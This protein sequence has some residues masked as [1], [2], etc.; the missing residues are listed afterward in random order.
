M[1]YRQHW[2]KNAD[3]IETQT[4][5]AKRG[6]VKRVGIQSS[7]I[8]VLPNVV[9]EVFYKTK[10]NRITSCH[11]SKIFC[12]AA[13]YPHKNLT[14]IPIV[15]AILKNKYNFKGKFYITIKK[16]GGI[17]KDI[18]RIAIELGVDN[19]IHNLGPIS[20]D[21]C[22]KYYNKCKIVFQP[23]LLEVFSATYLE[24]MIMGRPLVVPNLPFAKNVCGDSALYYHHDSA[25]EAAKCIYKLISDS[26]LYTKIAKLSERRAD[27]YPK[28]VDKQ[29]EIVEILLKL[30]NKH[31]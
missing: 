16:D 21:Q 8:F 9:N 10:K 25:D 20:L 14:I 12:L 17:Y 18:Y 23:S 11:A 24:S 4:Q 15:A 31:N 19:L 29:K 26:S 22:V 13:A 7:N 5:S 6:I 2:S 28:P 27:L 3:Y 1:L 30:S